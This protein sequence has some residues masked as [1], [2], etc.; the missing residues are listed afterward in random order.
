[1]VKS[2]KI[3]EINEIEVE[4]ICR[5]DEKFWNQPCYND[6]QTFILMG[7]KMTLTTIFDCI[8]STKNP[9][10][11]CFAI[12]DDCDEIIG[13]I[14]SCLRLKK[15]KRIL[16][17]DFL[18]LHP[19]FQHKGYGE[20]VLKEFLSIVQ[21]LFEEMPN[22]IQAEIARNNY[23]CMRLFKKLGFSFNDAISDFYYI[24]SLPANKLIKS[25]EE[26]EEINF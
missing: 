10:R 26:Q 1:M 17:I 23:A 20:Q 8:K 4:E 18:A 6:I 19:Y 5:W 11:Y 3:A 15:G 25:T 24:V 13:F 14:V 21:T 2:V 22:E 7:G 12:K 16:E 9:N